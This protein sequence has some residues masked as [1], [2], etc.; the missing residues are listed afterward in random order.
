[1]K[2]NGRKKMVESWSI[3]SSPNTNK[4]FGGDNIL[5]IKREESVRHTIKRIEEMYNI[6]ASGQLIHNQTTSWNI[7]C[8]EK[9]YRSCEHVECQAQA[10]PLQREALAP[11]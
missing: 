5:Q 3:S 1:M 8:Q 10:W 7:S 6:D 4:L 2:T 9:Q 11:L